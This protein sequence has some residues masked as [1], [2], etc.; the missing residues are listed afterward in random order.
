MH[1][2]QRVHGVLDDVD[3]GAVG[4]GFAGSVELAGVGVDGL[5]VD[6]GPAG[7]VVPFHG[8]E[9]VVLCCGKRV[10]LAWLVGEAAI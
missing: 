10:G 3:G 5:A 8:G 4:L 1:K 7:S 9:H 6:D 2:I